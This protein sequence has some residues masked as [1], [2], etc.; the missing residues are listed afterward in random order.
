M[1]EF[2]LK[3]ITPTK[4]VKTEQVNSVTAPGEEGELEVLPRHEHSFVLLKEG[5]VTIRKQGQ[6]DEFLAIGGGYLET[7]GK[8]LT[9]LVSHAY[10]QDEIDKEMVEKAM[11]DAKRILDE[12]KDK[13]D[14]AEAIA[15]LRRSEISLKLLQKHP[16]RRNIPSSSE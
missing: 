1:A 15:T 7:D 6:E 10:G 3:I 12:T 5:I 2:E 11:A 4:I 13:H 8:Q 9:I 16:R 14:Q